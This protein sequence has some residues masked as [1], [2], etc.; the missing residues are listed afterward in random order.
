MSRP[1]D[2]S[3]ASCQPTVTLIMSTPHSTACPISSKHSSSSLPPQLSISS[4]PLR[5]MMTG[6]SGVACFMPSISSRMK[7]PRLRVDPPYSSLRWLVNFEL[8]FASR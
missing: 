1:I 7:R 2:D 6:W 3:G 4:A 8:K 5:R